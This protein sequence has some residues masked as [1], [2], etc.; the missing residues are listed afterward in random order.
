MVA[1]KEPADPVLVKSVVSVVVGKV[2]ANGT[3][4]CAAKQQAGKNQ[5]QYSATFKAWGN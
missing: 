4:A 3:K 1:K 5:Y 2:V